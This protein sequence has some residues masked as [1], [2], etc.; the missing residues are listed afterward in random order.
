AGVISVSYGECELELGQ[1][2]NAF[3]S[4][5]WEQAAAQGQTVFVSA[6][7]GGSAGCDDFDAQQMAY[8]GLQVN[9]IAATPYDVAVGGTD[10]YFSQYGGS[11]SAIST[12]LA[13]YW[14]ASTTSPAVSLKQT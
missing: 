2:G 11:S 4:A 8:G 5:L 13:G 3:W 14:S 6:G 9:G 10:F 1:S 12:Q 7:D